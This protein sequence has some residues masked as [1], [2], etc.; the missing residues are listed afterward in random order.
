M[1]ILRFDSVGGASGDMILGSLLAL[2][3]PLDEI[4]SALKKALPEESFDLK[5]KPF[6]DHGISGFRLEVEVLKDSVHER[7]L[8]AIEHIIAHS[9]LPEGTK[10]LAT[11]VFRRLGEAEAKVHGCDVHHIHF[12]EV[13]A[14]DSIVDIVGSCLAL[15]LLKV[16]AIF[17][18]PLPEG[19]GTFKCRHGVY[20]IPAPATAELLKG[21]EVVV[22]D[23][24]FE[25]V[26]P[27]GAALL[28]SLPNAGKSP[29]G[30]A[31]A[32]ACSFG[33]RKL[34]GR[35]NVL[36]ATLM[37]S[38]AVADQDSCLLLETNL[39]DLSPE[40]SGSLFERLLSEG[41]LDVWTTPAFMKKQRQGLVLSVLCK[42]EGKAKLE[43]AI[44]EESGTFGIRCSEV[45]RSVLER[46]I[47]KVETK[48]GPVSVKAGFLDGAMVSM[49]PE[50]EDCLE[51]S[52]RVK[53]PLKE[54]MREALEAA[55]REAGK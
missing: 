47:S 9:S 10:S 46:K 42:A 49:K 22:T 29:S 18:G 8:H 44:F 24:P 17:F 52:K 28:T 41:A 7:G 15:H 38:S 43:K 13:G 25:M 11:H 55:R 1:R 31:V 23:E 34:K 45:S 2:G 40:V 21:V 19:Q 26:T 3:A 37:E 36:R 33:S 14:V 39:D 50:Y 35:P 16:D 51:I 48:F 30:K 32:S 6:S 27:T 5:L 12:H 4:S 54:V 20:P 53:A